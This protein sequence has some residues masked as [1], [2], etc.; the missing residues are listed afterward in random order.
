MEASTRAAVAGSTLRVRLMT[1]ETVVVETPARSATSRIVVMADP[2]MVRGATGV[3]MAGARSE[4][5]GRRVAPW[6]LA[7]HG[8]Q[9]TGYAMLMSMND[10]TAY[11]FVAGSINV[12]L[13]V[14]VPTLPGAGETVLGDRFIQQNGGKSANQAVAASRVGA[15]VTMLGAVGGDDFGRTAL[16]GIRD[17]GVD[18]SCC[19]VVQGVHT[20]L[21]LIVVDD[22]GENQIAVAS[23]AN[24]RLDARI[25]EAQV[26]ALRPAPG[27]VC[28]LGFEVSDEAV[29]AAARWAAAHELRIIVNPAPARPLVPELLALGPILTPNQTEAE[30]LTG[31]AEP[32]SAAKALWARTASPVV[33]TLGA[34]GALLFDGA[35]IERLP[36]LKVEPVDTTGA[37]DA[38]NGI[39]AA[40]LARGADLREALRWAMVGAALKTTKAGAQA[41]L[42]TREAIASHLDSSQ[43]A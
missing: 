17:A 42:P 36:T 2:V 41:G 4:T 9:R 21:A 5:L 39:L 25:I 43:L 40:E 38:L 20:G 30:M 7:E 22:A 33:V 8:P 14:G 35:T 15:T 18:T 24:G 27:G 37:G 1:C 31:E 3:D 6:G 26:A 12:D 13:I 10:T 34:D 19:N 16:A 23:G 29:V 32:A 28:L 11:V